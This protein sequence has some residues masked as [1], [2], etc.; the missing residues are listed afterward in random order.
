MTRHRALLR[1]SAVMLLSG[2]AVGAA[3]A[4]GPD[5]LRDLSGKVG[6]V[7]DITTDPRLLIVE[8]DH[9]VSNTRILGLGDEYA[10]GWRFSGASD[11][12]VTLRRGEEERQVRLATAAPGGANQGQIPGFAAGGE[13]SPPG[14]AGLGAFTGRGAFSNANPGAA[15]RGGGRGAAPSAEEITSALASGDINR[16]MEMRD[17]IGDDPQAMA[18]ALQGLIGAQG[19]D[20]RVMIQML[21]GGGRGGGVL[22]AP[23]GGGRGGG[24]GPGQ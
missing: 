21:G 8:T 18:E 24:R 4:Q 6:G 14:A 22:F 13:A 1:L 19:G 12:V 3:F 23:P 2:A 16:L 7:L 17:Q 11:N 9:G 5:P 20:P 15:R 10:G